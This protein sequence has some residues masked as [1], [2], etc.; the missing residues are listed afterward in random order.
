ME[1]K[2]HS[3]E[4][5][6]DCRDYWY[7]LDF[8]ELM[9]KRWELEKVNTLLDVGCGQCHWTRIVSRFL[10]KGAEVTAVDADPKWGRENSQLHEFFDEREIDFKIEKAD[11][12]KL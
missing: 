6:G 1:A 5:F 9:A 7:N 2:G 11:V 4:Y 8:L 12:L 10:G 3:E